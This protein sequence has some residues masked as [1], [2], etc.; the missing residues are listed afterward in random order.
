MGRRD[1]GRKHQTMRLIPFAFPLMGL[2]A[3]PAGAQTQLELMSG[4]GACPQGTYAGIDGCA[5][6]PGYFNPTLSFHDASLFVD[7]TFFQNGQ[8]VAA[9]KFDWNVAGKDF[10]VGVTPGT[11]CGGAYTPCSTTPGASG[12]IDASQYPW[13][14]VN[15]HTGC[16]SGTAIDGYGRLNCIV[17]GSG[18]INL[19]GFDWSPNEG[20]A[21]ETCVSLWLREGSTGANNGWSGTVNFT[22]NHWHMLQHPGCTAPQTNSNNGK[23]YQF[24]FFNNTGASCKIHRRGE[25]SLC[26]RGGGAGAQAGAGL[27]CVTRS[28]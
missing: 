23:Y 13:G 7:G 24:A 11:Y 21:G 9:S 1:E 18:T 3:L 10:A 16:G 8:S 2:L 14:T 20:H 4:P 28:I 5:A 19:I 15:D 17:T 22:N 6:A 27:S 26:S 25:F 12:L